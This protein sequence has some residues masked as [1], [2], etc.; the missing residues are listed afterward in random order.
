[1]WKFVA[2]GL[3]LLGTT[4][5]SCDSKEERPS[6]DD[7][8][9]TTDR[10]S[11]LPGDGD[12]DLG[13]SPGGDGNGSGGSPG[14]EGGMSNGGSGGNEIDPERPEE[15][16]PRFCPDHGTSPECED[17]QAYYQYE[18]FE[19]CGLRYVRKVDD[20]LEEETYFVDLATDEVLYQ[21]R[22]TEDERCLVAI[23]KTGGPPTC[24][25]FVRES[26][27]AFTP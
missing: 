13:G 21:A 14:G 16:A 18:T 6:C 19:G 1:M 2:L 5:L 17:E 9:E 25:D 22:F 10:C 4:L 11:E 26:C 7:A 24:E 12:G 27:D 23:D 3:T 20:L 8:D 15:R